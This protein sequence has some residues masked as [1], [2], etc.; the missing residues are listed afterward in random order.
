MNL[1]STSRAIILY[2]THT[3]EIIFRCIGLSKGSNPKKSPKLYKSKLSV[4]FICFL[5]KNLLRNSCALSF[6]VI[7]N[8]VLVYN[9]KGWP[10]Y[11]PIIYL[12]RLCIHS[13]N[14]ISSSSVSPPKEALPLPS[15]YFLG[16]LNPSS[17]S[18]L[19]LDFSVGISVAV[20]SQ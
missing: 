15:A 16:F 20:F 18:L 12:Y 13:L 3:A 5:Y 9:I 14:A 11:H 19:R 6:K 2:I 7:Y 1:V 17:I 8:L 4:N 10:S